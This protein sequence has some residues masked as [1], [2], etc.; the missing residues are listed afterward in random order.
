MTGG[1]DGGVSVPTRRLSESSDTQVLPHG[2][3]FHNDVVITRRFVQPVHSES[4]TSEMGNEQ[5]VQKMGSKETEFQWIPKDA[6]ASASTA[7]AGSSANLS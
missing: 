3:S 5:T 7:A 2:E 6:S 1:F 4:F